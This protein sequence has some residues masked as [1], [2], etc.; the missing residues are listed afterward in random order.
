[1]TSRGVLVQTLVLAWI[2]CLFYLQNDVRSEETELPPGWQRLTTDG[3]YKQ[4]PTWSPDGNLLMYSRQIDD[5]IRIVLHPRDGLPERVLWENEKPRFDAVFLPD[6][7][8]IALTFD[9]IT[10]GQGDMELYVSE[11]D[12]KTLKPLFVTEGKLSHEEWAS[13]SPDGNWI[14]CTSTRDDNS[15]LYLLRTDGSD[16]QRMT[17]DPAWDVHP[18][19]SPEGNRLAFA[20]N[21]WGDLE[22]AI[23]DL[24]TS[25]I[26]R[27]TKSPGFDDY[28]VWSPDGRQIAFTSRRTGNLEIFVMDADGSQLRNLTQQMGDENYPCWSPEGHLTFCSFRQGGWDIYQITP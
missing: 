17:S 22:I 1:M 26:E 8:R 4:R 13:P 14:A 2:A 25:L 6:G 28:P 9:K 18:S 5:E 11:L 3:H 27:L 7:K 16:R 12:G 20:T 19:F 23:Y 10:P 21:R 15:E 24:K